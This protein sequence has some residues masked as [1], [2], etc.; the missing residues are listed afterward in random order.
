MACR[1]RKIRRKDVS[2]MHRKSLIRGLSAGLAFLLLLC[3][4]PLSALA[5]EEAVAEDKLSQRIQRRFLYIENVDD[6]LQ[7]ARDCKTADYS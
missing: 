1:R 3:T 4:F 5:G 2:R 7:F 6:L